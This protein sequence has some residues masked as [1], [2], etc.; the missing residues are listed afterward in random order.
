MT[1]E[2]SIKKLTEQRER[3]IRW[4]EETPESERHYFPI[5]FL[6]RR[7]ARIGKAIAVHKRKLK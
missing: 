3:C 2:Q 4:L 6:S 5:C 7:I 1:P